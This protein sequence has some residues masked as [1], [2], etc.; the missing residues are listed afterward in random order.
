MSPVVAGPRGAGDLALG[1]TARRP[2][3]LSAS[4]PR[5]AVAQ[6]ARDGCL[7]VWRFKGRP[8]GR[9]MCVALRSWPRSASLPLLKL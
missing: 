9:H 5:K 3:S 6:V 2:V 4:T 1:P 7:R 8:I